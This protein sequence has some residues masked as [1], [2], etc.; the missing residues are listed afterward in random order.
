M[1]P[2]GSGGLSWDSVPWDGADRMAADRAAFADAEEATRG[3]QEAAP[4]MAWWTWREPTISL[5]FLAP[6]SGVGAPGVP[7]VRRPTGG[8]TIL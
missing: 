5:G 1:F 7:V 6:A 4:R 3:G 8:G 2:A